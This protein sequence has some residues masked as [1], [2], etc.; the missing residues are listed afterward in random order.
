ME[1][2]SYHSEESITSIKELQETI[3][4]GDTKSVLEL[5]KHYDNNKQIQNSIKYNILYP[6]KK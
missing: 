2:F 5:N 3:D 1:E 4:Y 6:L